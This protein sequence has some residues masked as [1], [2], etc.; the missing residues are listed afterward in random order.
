MPDLLS[1]DMD[2]LRSG[3]P[4]AAIKWGALAYT[5]NLGIQ[6]S[7]NTL[8]TGFWVKITVLGLVQVIVLSGLFYTSLVVE[9]PKRNISTYNK[10]IEFL[11][12]IVV[13]MWISSIIVG[14][15]L[16]KQLVIEMPSIVLLAIVLG[17][18]GFFKYEGEEAA[19]RQKHPNPFD[20]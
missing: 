15:F 17:V 4:L 7:V 16:A 14:S 11:A 8:S 9:A 2:L 10:Q 20:E 18:P 6:F 19:L 13:I 3:A 1:E 12:Y 5:L